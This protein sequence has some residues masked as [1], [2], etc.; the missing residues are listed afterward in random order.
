MNP[1]DDEKVS[2]G[3]RSFANE[4]AP[5][6]LDEF[7]LQE[8]AAAAKPKRSADWSSWIL[9]PVTIFA[10]LGI[11]LAVVLQLS[12]TSFVSAPKS[13]DSQVQQQSVSNEAVPHVEI[14][15]AVQAGGNGDPRKSSMSEADSALA[16]SDETAGVAERGAKVPGQTDIGGSGSHERLLDKS[17]PQIASSTAMMSVSETANEPVVRHCDAEIS[18]SATAWFDCI[19]RL[20]QAGRLAEAADERK[21]LQAA[22]PDF[23]SA[24]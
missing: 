12:D 10:S 24:R 16:T 11:S 13:T 1:R 23:E 17:A 3:Y 6:R 14:R 7:V 2:A 4:L 22:F 15:R 8:A 20:E 21:L 19:E 9:R 18:T 5:A